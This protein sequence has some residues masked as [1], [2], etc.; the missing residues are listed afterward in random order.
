M[1]IT[2]TKIKELM[3][4]SPKTGNAEI[5][6]RDPKKSGT[7]T[8]RGYN[9][10]T[11]RYRPL[12]DEYGNDRVLKIQ[13]TLYLNMNQK[14]DRLAYA[15][16]KNHP[17]YTKGARPILTVVN[18]E[19]DADNFVKLKDKEAK[20]MEIIQK[21]EG[22]DLRDFARILLIMVKPGSSDKVIKRTIYEKATINPDV[23]IDEWESELKDYKILI[24]KGIEK[25]VFTFKN[26]RYS[27]KEEL[28]GTSFET[29]LDW[30][31][32]NED[33][34]PSLNTMIK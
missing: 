21:L 23:I 18:H 24:R 26:G 9:D 12:I 25:G 16:I 17:I 27:F 33:L 29:A 19:E 13:K 10:E 6:L 15:H 34:I 5:R 7:I 1:E 3:A 28:M 4:D 20:A 32:N 2:D 14:N 8:V 31:K 22:E 30:L 11:G